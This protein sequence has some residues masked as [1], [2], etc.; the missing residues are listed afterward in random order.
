MKFP[1]PWRLTQ[2]DGGPSYS[3][4]VEDATGRKLFYI[5]ADDNRD[6][7]GKPGDENGPTVYGYS[8]DDAHLVREIEETLGR[9]DSI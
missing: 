7:D 5:V 3:L 1:K 9:L 6:G 2:V 8:N 4:H